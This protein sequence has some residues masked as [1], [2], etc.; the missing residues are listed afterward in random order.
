MSGKIPSTKSGAPS[1]IVTDDGAY[2]IFIVEK[3]TDNKFR[4]FYRPLDQ[5]DAKP[6]HLVGEFEA[7]Y[8]FIDNDGP[9]FWFK[10]NKNAPRGK[11]V[12]IDTRRPEPAHWIDVIPEA[13][14]TLESVD[15][16]AD[17]FLASYLKDAHTV[18][19]VFDIEGPARP[20]R[21]F[22]GAGNREWFPRQAERQRNVL[23]VQLVH[24]ARYDLSL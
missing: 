18:V 3:G 9:V 16:V 23:R 21:R 24:H 22:P 4:V 6:I 17:H 11:V 10:T 19:R 7:D 15:I 5:P 13:A 1:R 2:L 14:D 8:T 20:R 12:A